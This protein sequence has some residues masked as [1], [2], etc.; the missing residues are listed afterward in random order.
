MLS[1]R[2]R[3]RFDYYYRLLQDK[4]T[5]AYQYLNGQWMNNRRMGVCTCHQFH[6]YHLPCSYILYTYTVGLFTGDLLQHSRRWS[7]EYNFHV[8]METVERVPEAYDADN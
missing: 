8:C 2:F 4:F 7:R 5:Q 6:D 1:T 3:E